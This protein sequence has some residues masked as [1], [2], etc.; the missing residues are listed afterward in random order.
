M[1]VF[2]A[3]TSADLEDTWLTTVLTHSLQAA[4]LQG[5][6]WWLSAARIWSLWLSYLCMQEGASCHCR[7]HARGMLWFSC[8]EAG[9]I[10]ACS[11]CR[12]QVIASPFSLVLVAQHLVCIRNLLELVVSLRQSVLVF[13]C[14]AERTVCIAPHACWRRHSTCSKAQHAHEDPGEPG[15]HC[16]ACKRYAFLMA[17]LSADCGIPS[18][19]KIGAARCTRSLEEAQCGRKQT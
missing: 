15:C 19:C 10:M 4:S 5:S 9:Q 8:N 3:H 6:T 11:I 7:L 12:R 17:A 16:S 13:V 14:A 2:Q 1:P 18:T